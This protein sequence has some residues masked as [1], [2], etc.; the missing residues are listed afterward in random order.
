MKHL[1]HVKVLLAAIRKQHP[2]CS[3]AASWLAG[4]D[5]PRYPITERLRSVRER[6]T[7]P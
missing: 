5:Q 6:C 3:K 1:L 4:R 2:D 7:T